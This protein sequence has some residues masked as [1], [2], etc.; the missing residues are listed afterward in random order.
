MIATL[1]GVVTPCLTD[2]CTASI[3]SSCI[4]AAHSP[5]P[6]LVNSLPK[7]VEPRKFTDSTA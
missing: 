4:L 6:A 1:S 5:L 3:K 7:P 2:H